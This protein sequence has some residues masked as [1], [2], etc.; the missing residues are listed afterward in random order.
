MTARFALAVTLFLSLAPTSFA[1]PLEMPDILK[2][3]EC[4]FCVRTHLYVEDLDGNEFM[5]LKRFQVTWRKGFKLIDKGGEMDQRWQGQTIYRWPSWKDTQMIFDETNTMIYEIKQPLKDRHLNTAESY[6]N[7]YVI[8]DADDNVVARSYRTQ[9]RDMVPGVD[10]VIGTSFS[11][12]DPVTHEE[13]AKIT[14]PPVIDNIESDE[15]TVQ[16]FD[17][18]ALDP[19][20]Y[21]FIAAGKTMSTNGKSE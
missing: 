9:A 15:W 5:R 18:E 13:I 11:I 8:V 1:T 20:V 3:K 21:L 7:H 19:R 16:I 2:I 10:S 6:G 12:Q 4:Y 14:S 17:H